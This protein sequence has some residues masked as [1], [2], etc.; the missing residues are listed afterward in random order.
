MGAVLYETLSGV[1]VYDGE[2]PFEILTKIATTRPAPLPG[3][4]PEVDAVLQQALA[5]EPEKRFASVKQLNRA[6]AL[7]LTGEHPI[8]TPSQGVPTLSDAAT[9]G[10]ASVERRA[11]MRRLALG[12]AS[13][14]VVAIAVVVM[15]AVARHGNRRPATLAAATDAPTTRAA[16]TTT[17]APAPAETGTA[18]ST[19]AEVTITVSRTPAAARLELDGEPATS[20]LR[21]LRSSDKHVL[22]ARAP[23]HRERT[24]DLVADQDRTVEVRLEPIRKAR[25]KSKTKPR[26]VGGAEL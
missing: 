1:P 9:T 15:V 10:A 11:R 16:P 5:F 17:V 6:L 7:A 4:P 2:T 14:A 18:A 26:L 13:I 3:F 24:V 19:P 25:V 8:A 23:G 22:R 21:L 20:P 12:A